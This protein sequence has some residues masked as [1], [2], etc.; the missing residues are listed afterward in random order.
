VDKGKGFPPLFLFPVFL[1]LS[2]G[3][4]SASIS[5]E[6]KEADSHFWAGEKIER[7]IMLTN[8]S[9]VTEEVIFTWIGGLVLGPFPET[10]AI[11]QK[12][13]KRFSLAPG[14]KKNILVILKFPEVKS[15]MKYLLQVKVSG[16]STSTRSFYYQIFPH[17][18]FASLAAYLNEKGVGVYDPSGR[19]TSIFKELGVSFSLINNAWGWDYF[20]GGF[21]FVGSGAFLKEN[22][23]FFNIISGKVAN[24]A[25]VFCFTQNSSEDEKFVASEGNFFFLADTEEEKAG[26]LLLPRGKGWIIFSPFLTA[27]G[28]FQEPL[29]QVIFEKA[30]KRMIEL[31]PHSWCKAGY[32]GPTDDELFSFLKEIG[33]AN[34]PSPQFLITSLEREKEIEECFYSKRVPLVIFAFGVEKKSAAILS[35]EIPEIKLKREDSPPLGLKG[36]FREKRTILLRLPVS[37]SEVKKDKVWRS[38]IVQFLTAFGIPLNEF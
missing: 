8:D 33:F 18:E 23:P 4:L 9:P 12:E 1:F 3:W 36:L 7:H 14:E 30:L 38:T 28:F 32:L 27:E 13:E 26:L 17:P 6:V 11:A 2:S 25:R 21:I 16:N 20:S 37:L 19:V 29:S 5:F 10:L 15:R 35:K 31:E 22:N 34:F 24:G